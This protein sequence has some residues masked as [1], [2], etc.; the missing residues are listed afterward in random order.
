MAE[1][2]CRARSCRCPAVPRRKPAGLQTHTRKSVLNQNGTIMD[3]L[4]PKKVLHCFGAAYKNNNKK[5][6]KVLNQNGTIMDF[7]SFNVFICLDLLLVLLGCM[8]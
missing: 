6:V 7:L 2:R 8:F 1:N 5:T 3:F 4:F